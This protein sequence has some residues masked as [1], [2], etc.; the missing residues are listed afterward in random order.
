MN[1]TASRSWSVSSL[2]LT[3]SRQA[4]S[5]SVMESCLRE[6]HARLALAELGAADAD[7]LQDPT[8]EERAVAAEAP[9]LVHREQL[10]GVIGEDL[11]RDRRRVQPLLATAFDDHAGHGRQLVG[12]DRFEDR[13]G[14]NLFVVGLS[15]H[16]ARLHSVRKDA[17]AMDQLIDLADYEAAAR[18]TLEPYAWE[19]LALGAEPTRRGSRTSPPGN[20]GCSSL[21]SCATCPTSTCRRP[22]SAP[23]S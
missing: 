3:S 6:L 8:A 11:Q 9:G 13:H 15:A 4:T 10:A 12:G 20:G 14:G 7:Q 2:E 18:A 23:T 5:S 17:P 22:C 16:Y 19:Y 1:V 21:T